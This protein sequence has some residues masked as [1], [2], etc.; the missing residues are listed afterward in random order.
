M[1]TTVLIPR[2]GPSVYK[3]KKRELICYLKETI[4]DNPD[5]VWTGPGWQ[6]RIQEWIS[7]DYGRPPL[8]QLELVDNSAG[9]CCILVDIDDPSM[10]TLVALKFGAG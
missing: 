2:G 4:G 6:I 7:M 1:T 5:D 3:T 8:P 9:R 10:A